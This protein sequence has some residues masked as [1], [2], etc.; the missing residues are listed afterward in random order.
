M[1]V[2]TFK[3]A[4][5]QQGSLLAPLEKKILIDLA[6]RMP[7]WVNS[8][9][10]TLLGFLGMI[11]SGLCYYFAKWNPVALVGAVVCLGINWFGDSLDGT[12]ARVRDQQR[13]RYGFYVDHIADSAGVIVLLGGLG[14]SGYM[15]SALAMALI[16][17][18]LLLSIELF[19]ATYAVGLF[20]LS[21]GI[22][23]PTELRVVLAIGTFV[24]FENPTVNVFGREYLLCDA[25][26]VVA[27]GG[28]LLMTI[29]NTVRNT[30]RL[31][32][33]EKLP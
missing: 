24:M 17:A 9:H 13:P 2:S 14:L 25:G 20:R 11:L 7:R 31:Y 16:I 30:I 19:L 26:A 4:P 8:D 27:I 12:L 23:G 10:L 32:R 15:T 1:A 3:S 18:Y 5:R 33:E 21:F 22:W 29:I 6:R 28:I